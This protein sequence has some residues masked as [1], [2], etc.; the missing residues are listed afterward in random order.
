MATK[1]TNQGE[2]I[3]RCRKQDPK[4]KSQKGNQE[5]TFKGSKR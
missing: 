2:P 4:D 5:Q 3:L 1:G